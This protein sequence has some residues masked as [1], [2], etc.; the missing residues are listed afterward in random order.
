[1]P[2]FEIVMKF[3]FRECLDTLCPNFY[4]NS[5]VPGSV[6]MPEHVDCKYNSI[7]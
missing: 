5:T 2:N 7:A 1:M 4:L 6:I 3:C